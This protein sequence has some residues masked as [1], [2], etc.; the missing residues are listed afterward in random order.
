MTD[1]VK[2]LYVVLDAD[3]RV[4]DVEAIVN[5]IKMVKCVADVQ[6]E[7]MVSGVDDYMARTRVRSELA[8]SLNK[9]IN[10]ILTQKS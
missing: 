2:G 10:D 1:R 8:S 4:D 7:D 6:T 5:A 9:L 3:Y